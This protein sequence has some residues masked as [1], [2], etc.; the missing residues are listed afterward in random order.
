MR[1]FVDE[2][3]PMAA[4]LTEVAKHGIA[5]NYARSL[6]KALGKVEDKRP[7]KQGLVEPVSERELEVL[8]LLGTDL[9]PP[10]AMG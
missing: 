4:S 1:I 9:Y 3:P 8:K 6:L 10:W 5:P 7:I 2:G